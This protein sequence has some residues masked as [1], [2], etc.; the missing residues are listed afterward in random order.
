MGEGGQAEAILPLHAGPRT[1]QQMD[2]KLDAL[3]SGGR[4]VQHVI[5][6]DGRQI[7]SATLPYV[8]AHVAA[9]AARGALTK[10]TVF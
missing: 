1:L 8:D 2:A 9:K 6:L 3:L 7:A 4:P 5:N 10:R